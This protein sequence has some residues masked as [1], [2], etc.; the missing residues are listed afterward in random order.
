[1]GDFSWFLSKSNGWARMMHSLWDFVTLLLNTV[2]SFC[3]CMLSTLRGSLLLQVMSLCWWCLAF[4]GL[5]CHPFGMQ[6]S[7]AG[8]LQKQPHFQLQLSV[9]IHLS[10]WRALGDSGLWDCQC[11]APGCVCL[12]KWG[13]S[14]LEN[15]VE[16][17]LCGGI[18]FS[19]S[20]LVQTNDANFYSSVRLKPM[21]E[22]INCFSRIFQK[23]TK[24]QPSWSLLDSAKLGTQSTLLA[25]GEKCCECSSDR[26]SEEKGQRLA[27]KCQ[28]AWLTDPEGVSSVS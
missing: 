22:A 12:E 3:L 23:K 7:Q 20:T 25:T 6:W 14:M 5:T 17:R 15:Q 18:T 24:S 4:V 2:L 27:C 8:P 16:A 10:V 1:M 13:R 9:C 28:S 26:N 21:R 19:C 11:P